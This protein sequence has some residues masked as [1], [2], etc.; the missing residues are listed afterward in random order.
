MRIRS[1]TIESARQVST[2]GQT[3]G[4]YPLSL[5]RVDWIRRP[6]EP[7]TPAPRIPWRPAPRPPAICPGSKSQ[8]SSGTCSAS[9]G[10]PR[11]GARSGSTSIPWLLAEQDRIRKAGWFNG[12]GGSSDSPPHV[13]RWHGCSA[14][15]P[16]PSCARV[17]SDHPTCPLVSLRLPCRQSRHNRDCL[18]GKETPMRRDAN[19][20][21]AKKELL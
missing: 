5:R 10:P 15:Y 17:L 18:R 12:V 3:S 20:A 4:H 9:R 16:R 11:H 21:K 7:V 19:P 13:P 14:I 2:A 8:C 1:V 6:G